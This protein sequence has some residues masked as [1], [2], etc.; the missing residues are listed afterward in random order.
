MATSPIYAFTIAVAC[1]STVFSFLACL[2]FFL[3]ERKSKLMLLITLLLISDGF[4]SLNFVVWAVADILDSDD[5]LFCRILLPFQN[6]SILL[7]F[8]FTILIA[9][10]FSNVN[11]LQAGIKLNAY[12]MWVVP[13]VSFILTLPIIV[14]NSI[15]SRLSIG[16]LIIS[17]SASDTDLQDF[18]YYSSKSEAF[19]VNICCLQL[20]TLCAIIYNSYAYYTGIQMLKESAPA[21]SFFFLSSIVT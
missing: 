3:Y 20:P 4:I 7:S 17:T 15:S 16:E 5:Q 13:L 1:C 11:R 19:I 12:P 10:R 18:C 6:M 8:G 2:L 9:Q 21:V 14:L